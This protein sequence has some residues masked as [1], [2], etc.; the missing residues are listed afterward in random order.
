MGD[1]VDLK[2]EAE[3]RHEGGERNIG[4]GRQALTRLELPGV[5]YLKY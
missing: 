3:E 4:D 1:E 5:R 2:W